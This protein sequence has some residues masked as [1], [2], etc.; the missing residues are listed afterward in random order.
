MGFI[1]MILAQLVILG[2]WAFLRFEMAHNDY[3][4][5]NQ[6]EL[7]HYDGFLFLL[8]CPPLQTVWFLTHD[9]N[10]LLYGLFLI[11]ISVVSSLD[12]IYQHYMQKKLNNPKYSTP[13]RTWVMKYIYKWW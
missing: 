11:V 9:I 8:L 12:D 6:N 2:I 7:H 13:L 3:F 5:F 4:L 10:Y 1:E